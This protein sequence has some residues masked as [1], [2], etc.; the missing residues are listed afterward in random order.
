MSADPDSQLEDEVTL[1]QLSFKISNGRFD[2]VWPPPSILSKMLDSVRWHRTLVKWRGRWR[3]A[4]IKEGCPRKHC[5]FH[6]R[7][8]SSPIFNSLINSFQVTKFWLFFFFKSKQQSWNFCK[9]LN[10]K[11]CGATSKSMLKRM[12]LNSNSVY[13]ILWS[14]NKKIMTNKIENWNSGHVSTLKIHIS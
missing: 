4:D 10:F 6:A 12:L 14:F 2:L 13:I 11:F 9:L 3:G 8:S 7:D 5:E 1:H